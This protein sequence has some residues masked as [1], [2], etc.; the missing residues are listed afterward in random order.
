MANKWFSALL[1]FFVPPLA[2]VYLAKLR[3][4]AIFFLLMVCSV[5]ADYYVA[6]MVGFAFF[7]L[8]LSVVSAVYA[9]VL[10]KKVQF[11]GI[12][13]WYSWWWGVLSIPVT[14]FSLVFLIRSFAVE[15]FAIPSSSMSPTVEVGDHILVYKWGYGI[16]GSYGFTL[17]ESKTQNRTKPKWGDVMVLNPP[18]DSRPFVERIVGLPGD[19]VEF[20]NKQ[21]FINDL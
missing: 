7:A 9:F 4:A 19:V 3:I 1:G 12:R 10:A 14:F 13:K 17:V 16:Y 11:E 20:D 5:A 15:P 18:H 21:L 6:S 8:L 2:F